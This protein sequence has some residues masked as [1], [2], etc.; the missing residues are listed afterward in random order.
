MQHQNTLSLDAAFGSACACLIRQDGESFHAAS[1]SDKPHSQSIL[2]MLASLLAEAELGWN[3]LQLLGVGIG[4]GSFTGLRVV[5]AI[6][7]GINAGLHLPMLGIS[8]LAITACQTH[9]REPI[10]VIEDARTDSAWT[11]LYQES[12]PLEEDHN[13]S[14]DKL[15]RMP[16]DSYLTH[17]PATV[18][19][20]GWDYLPFDSSRCEALFI[21]TRQQVEQLDHP[22]KLPRVVTPTY[23]SPSQAERNAR[24]T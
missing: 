23:L 18:N 7:A 20:P 4:P 11:G 19:L 16:A 22:D 6:M 10:R 5:A 9:S 14:W 13:Q 15:R 17:T 12:I 3:A 8:S 2:P 21:L 24:R 1:P